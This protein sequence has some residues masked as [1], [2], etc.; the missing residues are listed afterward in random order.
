ML[1]AIALAPALLVFAPWYVDGDARC[2][3]DG[4]DGAPFCTVQGAFDN[5]ALAPGDEI[6]LRTAAVPYEG[7]RIGDNGAPPAVSGTAEQP[8]VMRPDDGHSPVLAGALAIHHCAYWTVRGLVFHGAGDDSPL[9]AIEVFTDGVVGEV[10][11]IVVEDNTILGFGDAPELDVGPYSSVGI[12]SVGSWTPDDTPMMIAPIIRNNRVRDSRGPGV[13][14]GRARDALIEGNEIVG[15]GCQLENSYLEAEMDYYARAAVIGVRVRRSA[16]ARIVR[17]R[18]DDLDVASCDLFDVDSLG[19]YGIWAD[20]ALE[21]E[22]DHNLVRDIGMQAGAGMGI[23]IT[24]S[25][26]DARVHH[27][28][29]TRADRCGICNGIESPGGADRVRFVN[30]TIVGGAQYGFDLMQG[31]G[32]FIGNNL[33]SGTQDAAIRILAVEGYATN[34]SADDNLYW[35]D[36][37]GAGIGQIGWTVETDL[38]TWQSDCGC[39]ASSV[40]ADPILPGSAA[41][42]D[43]TVAATSPVIDAG[44]ELAEVEAWNG[45]A[46]D[47]GALEAPVP[48]SASIAADEPARVHVIIEHNG[49]GAL[50]VDPDCLGLSVEIDGEAAALDGCSTQ[51]NGEIVV[52]LAQPVWAGQA[53]MLVHAGST[54][55]DGARIGGLVDAFLRPFDLVVDNAVQDDAPADTGTT[56]DVEPGTDTTNSTGGADVTGTDT[57]AEPGIDDGS[58]PDAGAC[59]CS[60]RATGA[61]AW[62][63]LLLLPLGAPRRSTH[64][65]RA[66]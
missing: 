53:V 13:S 37:S 35:D 59:E 28:I 44:S 36:G 56:T 18:I 4:S 6:L 23:A 41:P 63:W 64:R 19:V 29:V 60:T 51:G 8:I 16:G 25:S 21:V 40:V 38:A 10:H 7:A 58:Y 46:P 1:P 12:I 3:G 48:V 47:V 20:A 11:G 27:N 65:E 45:A 34:W 54:I 17:N 50:A 43:F 5:A 22:V 42:E 61:L 49:A 9:F 66:T 33:V 52:E 26:H 32:A 31:D 2:P 39:D 62:A 24:Q 57:G 55:T 14:V 15:L 30:N